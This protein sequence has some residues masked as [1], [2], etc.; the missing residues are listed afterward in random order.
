MNAEEYIAKVLTERNLTLAVVETTTGGLISSRLTSVPGSSKFYLIG[1]I[2]YSKSSKTTSL[3]INQDLLDKFGA[4]SEDVAMA[5]A[6]QIR[7]LTNV[8]IGLAETGIAGPI[9]GRSAKPIGTAFIAINM[10][11]VSYVEEIKCSGTRNEIR[12]EICRQALKMLINKL[13]PQ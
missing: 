2:A 9:Q 13:D 8:D 7:A 12:E 4:V 10:N 11:G 5:M 1:L 6:H 3:K